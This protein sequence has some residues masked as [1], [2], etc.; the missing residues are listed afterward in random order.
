MSFGPSDVTRYSQTLPYASESFGLYQPLLGWRAQRALRRFVMGLAAS[1]ADF[2]AASTRLVF[3]DVAVNADH[4]LEAFRSGR[5]DPARTYSP[6]IG[7]VIGDYI[8]SKTEGADTADP[9]FWTKLL[10]RDFLDSV[11]N[12]EVKPALERSLDGMAA[13]GEEKLLR[14]EALARRESVIAG[15]LLLL[16][17]K[18]RVDVLRSLFTLVGPAGSPAIAAGIAQMVDPLAT[19][20]PAHDWN[21]VGLSPVGIVHLFRQYFFEFD[22]FLGTPVQHLWLS[23]GGTVELVE[24]N[25]RKT[26]VERTVEQSTESTTKSEKS[27]T[28]QDDLSDAV[29]QDNE[30]N[31]KLGASVTANERWGWGDA[32]ETATIDY[33]STE[34]TAREQ[35][36]KSMRQQS[37]KL[38]TELKTNFKTTFRTVTETTDTTSRRYVLSNTTET[39]VNYELRRKMR[40]VGVQVQDLGAQL[41][42]QTY[43]DDP[44][45]DLG[46]AKLIHVAA[47]ADFSSLGPINELAVPDD[48]TIEVTGTFS[49]ICG[50]DDDDGSDIR[51]WP[52]CYLPLHPKDGFQYFDHG[53]VRWSSP[54]SFTTE[55]LPDAVWKP[56]VD[57]LG[58][59]PASPYLLVKATWG[60][61][62]NGEQFAFT[63][64]VTF[65]P[66]PDKLTA[67]SDQNK[68][69]LKDRSDERDRLSRQ[70][71]MTATVDRVKVAS[72]IQPRSYDDLRDEER[73]VVYRKLIQDL[74]SVGVDLTADRRVLHKAAELI[75]TM[76]DV[77]AMLYFVA[78]EWWRPHSHSQAEQPNGEL[79]STPPPG[80]SAPGAPS[81]RTDPIKQSVTISRGLS[82]IDTVAASS[83][84]IRNSYDITAGSAPA[85][86]G[87]SLGWLLQLD[88]DNQRNA[89]L[90]APWVKAVIP[91]RPGKEF[92]AINWIGHTTI[93]GAEG[94]DDRYQASSD[95]ETDEIAA[96]LEKS[97]WPEGPQRDRYSGFA[98]HIAAD[99]TVWYVSVRDALTYLALRVQTMQR[100]AEQVVSEDLG[101]GVKL[102]YLRPDMVY[103]HGFDPLQGGFRANSDE[104]QEYQ[105]FSQWVE[106]LPTDQIVAVQVTYDPITGRQIPL[107]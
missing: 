38:T 11:L 63:V 35:T 13:A 77:D 78:P 20:D 17:E 98:A 80:K 48:Y 91:I 56:A 16:A 84:H 70:A 66:S 95:A 106:V 4:V 85:P 49:L 40:Q 76:F 43:V 55:F 97:S 75:S 82:G 45:A 21:K 101:D 64:P 72:T 41:C 18:S 67:I 79:V 58:N 24:I 15:T 27:L 37:T 12:D 6:L 62:H 57:V 94:L 74:C 60:H 46:I 3:P 29:K 25:T 50:G 104:G 30:D 26:T 8:S 19:F 10:T 47:P 52:I 71:F 44:G 54:G 81:P 68:A 34:K 59:P 69:L 1:H 14:L 86:L 23:P 61:G 31:I 87:S 36:H 88:G 92:D 7:S 73:V 105:P 96:G 9:R 28:T 102:N 107:P 2:L 103:E 5:T 89:F 99:P 42:W 33:S 90:N 93:E 100:A 53:Q 22:T 32:T 65:T 83:L 39:L 51:N